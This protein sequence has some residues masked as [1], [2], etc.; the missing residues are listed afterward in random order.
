MPLYYW[1][2]PIYIRMGY[3]MKVWI[4]E[5]KCIRGGDMQLFTTQLMAENYSRYYTNICH[6]P[7]WW[8]EERKVY[9]SAWWEQ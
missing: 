5:H 7:E 8:I 2:F 1:C 4:Y 3:D 6:C 9:N